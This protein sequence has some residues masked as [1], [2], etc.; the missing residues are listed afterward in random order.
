LHVR[1]LDGALEIASV[2]YLVVSLKLVEAGTTPWRRKLQ[3]SLMSLGK[4][5]LIP[6]G[7]S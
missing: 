1:L 3:Y 2:C 7:V 5:T 4:E 6:F